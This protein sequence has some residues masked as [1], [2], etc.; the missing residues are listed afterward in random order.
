MK[1]LEYND[2]RV[3]GSWASNLTSGLPWV[4]RTPVFEIIDSKQVLYTIKLLD[5][6]VEGFESSLIF[7]GEDC[8][9][10]LSEKPF[11]AKKDFVLTYK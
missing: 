4:E 7:P 1:E 2:L 3:I 8:F 5:C 9:V 6:G 10:P 11:K